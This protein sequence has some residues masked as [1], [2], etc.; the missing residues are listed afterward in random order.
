MARS[1]LPLVLLGL[2]TACQTGSNR[3]EYAGQ[4]NEH[5]IGYDQYM[6]S[7]RRAFES[8]RLEH[9]VVPIGEDQSRLIELTWES[10]VRSL[11]LTDLYRDYGIH[12]T[13]AEVLDSLLAN[14]PQL[15]RESLVLQID[16]EF[17]PALYENALRTGEP[18]DLEWLKNHYYTA[19]IPLQKL[20]M[21]VLAE[22]EVSEDE[23]RREYRVRHGRAVVDV[24]AVPIE[25][26][27]EPVVSQPDIL[28]W[29]DTHRSEFTVEPSCDLQWVAFHVV[30]SPQDSLAAK[31]KID[32][33]ELRLRQGD[34]FDGL[35]RLHSDAASATLGG[36]IGYVP[37]DSLPPIV[38]RQL[39][40]RQWQVHTDPFQVNGEW[41]IYRPMKKTRNLVKLQ[42][43]VVRPRASRETLTKVLAELGLFAELTC[44]VGIERAATEFGLEVHTH[45]GASR[46]N[47]IIPGLGRSERTVSQAIESRPGTLFEPIYHEPLNSYILVRVLNSESGGAR[48]LLEVSDSIIAKLQHER[49]RE[50]ALERAKELAK[51]SD[52]LAVASQ[53]GYQV[54]SVLDFSYETI[55]LDEWREDINRQVLLQK[56]GKWKAWPELGDIAWT[57]N[58]R[59]I[60][61]P[62]PAGVAAVRSELVEFVRDRKR[63]GYFE[64]WLQ[65]QIEQARVRDWRPTLPM[66][67]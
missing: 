5:L 30:P 66:M 59:H 26:L 2:L 58:L 16:V 48:P 51:Q 33:L 12:V 25:A 7:V 19:Y 46:E 15:V 9:L 53:S 24:I 28:A 64:Q 54:I 37:V 57:L 55:L 10:I 62:D 31:A 67:Q 52:P 35:A 34:P 14:P 49:R 39:A 42:E 45:R 47:P 13:Q 8:Y 20:K 41:I 6:T 22:I 56:P 21:A 27:P 18:V 23:A 61:S 36:D 11:V 63:E 3:R 40:A 44:D 4:V 50:A 65:E 29:Y 32:S 38:L 1:L 17:S 43:I 60:E